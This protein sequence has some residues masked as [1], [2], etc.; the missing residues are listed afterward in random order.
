MM[1]KLTHF[2]SLIILTFFAFGSIESLLAQEVPVN[3]KPRVVRYEKAQ[4]HIQALKKGTL[5]IRLKTDERKIEAL[6]KAGKEEEAKKMLADQQQKHK[7]I[8]N[9]FSKAY[10]FS[11][12]YFFYNKNSREIGA[13]NFAG[14]LL[15]ANL[16]PVNETKVA[17]T[18]Y[19]L[20]SEEVMF[21]TM[22]S[23]VVGFGVLNQKYE[24]LEEPFPYYVRKREG[25]AMF[26]RTYRDMVLILQKE[27]HDFYNE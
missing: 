8:A 27:F 12:F 24:L 2:Y 16:N 26:R 3:E 5:L 20:D 23:T 10:T 15:D 19:V 7:E 18:F 21:E 22:N 9:A 17:E 4:K 6:K 25:L 1:M 13:R 11:K 14:L